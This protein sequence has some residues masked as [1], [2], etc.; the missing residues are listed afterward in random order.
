[1]PDMSVA[2]AVTACVLIGVLQGSIV[3]FMRILMTA[4]SLSR[5]SQQPA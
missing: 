1:M 3:A 2:V 5:H 4:D